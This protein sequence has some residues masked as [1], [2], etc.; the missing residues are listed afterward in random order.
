[1]GLSQIATGY[2]AHEVVVDSPEHDRYLENQSTNHIASIVDAWWGRNID[3]E[4]DPQLRYILIF[5]NH[6]KEAGASLRHP[7]EQII[8][9]TIIPTVLK[10]KLEYAK[11]H[12]INGEG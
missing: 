3:L 1:M 11:E 12:Y 6:G 8:A 10:T 7:H 4:R 5:K 9:T 2:G